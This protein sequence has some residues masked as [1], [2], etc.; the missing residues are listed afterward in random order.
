MD[1]VFSQ[2][3]AEGILKDVVFFDVDVDEQQDLARWETFNLILIL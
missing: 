2:I 3:E 1:T